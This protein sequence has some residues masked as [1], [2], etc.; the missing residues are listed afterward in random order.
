MN[1]MPPN[2]NVGLAFEEKDLKDIYVAGGCFWGVEAYMTR[3]FGVAQTSVGYANGIK[4]NP[5]YKEVC[6]GKTGHAETC[7]LMYDAGKISLKELLE[8]FF[9]I[10]EPT[11]LNKQGEDI[12]SQYRTGIYFVNDEDIKVIEEVMASEQLKYEKPIVTE[13]KPLHKYYL[14]E[15]Y[16]QDYL[17]K[18]PDGYCHIS[19]DTVK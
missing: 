8:K 16:H 17:E 2:P 4:E 11:S 12:G 7:H 3:V 18:N 5:T 6:T 15:E 9:E 14:A 10:I 1:Y 13:V 19:F